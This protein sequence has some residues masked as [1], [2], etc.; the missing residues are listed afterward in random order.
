M[1]NSARY[2]ETTLRAAIAAALSYL[3]VVSTCAPLALPRHHSQKRDRS[4]GHNNNRRRRT[5]NTSCWCDSA[6]EL[7]S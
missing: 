1:T 5:E 7:Q 4:E 3:L 2:R 6:P